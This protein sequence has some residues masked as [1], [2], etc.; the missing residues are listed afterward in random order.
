LNVIEFGPDIYGVRAAA[1]HY[2]GRRPAEL[3]LAE[4]LFLASLLP[5]PR[6]Y[7]KIYEKGDV[8]PSWMNHIHQLM[9]YAHKMGR[10]SDKD[11][12]EAKAEAI[13]FHQEDT[14]LPT[15]RPPV[16]G[17]HFTGDDTWETN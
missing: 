3:N 8:P 10:I 1:E 2:F 14:P 4:C 13:V 15:P 11:Y 5:N 12:D 6:G 16:A 17:A 9:D 7:H